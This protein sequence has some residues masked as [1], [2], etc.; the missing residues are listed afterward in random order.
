M[1]SAS[2]NYTAP[3]NSSVTPRRPYQPSTSSQNLRLSNGHLANGLTKH[4]SNYSYLPPPTRKSPK[5]PHKH[6]VSTGLEV[7]QQMIGNIVSSKETGIS[8]TTYNSYL[9]TDV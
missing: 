6:M 7:E 2:G 8:N 1:A 4:L 9:R 3:H 5:L